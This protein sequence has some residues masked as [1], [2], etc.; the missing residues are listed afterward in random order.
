MKTK[1]NL[2]I[3]NKLAEESAAELRN[4]VAELCVS[5]LAPEEVAAP[6]EW[7]RRFGASGKMKC[8]IFKP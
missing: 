3:L 5:E 1:P 6:A 4:M 8:P 2:I 7:G